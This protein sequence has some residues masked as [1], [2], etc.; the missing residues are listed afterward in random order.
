MQFLMDSWTDGVNTAFDGA[1][2][3]STAVRGTQIQNE[4]FFSKRI[5]GKKSL[6]PNM[7]E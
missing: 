7:N 2:N 6:D 1:S 5:T 3:F 4:F